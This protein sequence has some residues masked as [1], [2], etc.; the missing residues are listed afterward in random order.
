MLSACLYKLGS[1]D[2]QSFQNVSQALEDRSI[3][4]ASCVFQQKGLI[5]VFTVE[6]GVQHFCNMPNTSAKFRCVKNINQ[7][8]GRVGDVHFTSSSPDGLGSKEVVVPRV[9][10]P[11]RRSLDIGFRVS[12][13][14]CGEQHRR[15]EKLVRQIP[16]FTGS[17]PA[18]IAGGAV[19][20]GSDKPR[21]FP[22]FGGYDSI[23]R[24]CR[25][26][27]ATNAHQPA[28]CRKICE[29]AMGSLDGIAEGE[30]G[31]FDRKRS[32]EFLI[33]QRK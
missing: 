2:A 22:P 15:I 9:S 17:P 5:K 4:Q 24:D 30:G 23:Q 3:S 8:A 18:N 1:L 16:V 6:V 10:D 33:E 31:F 20:L 12:Y 25:V 28:P 13:F 32:V 14:S 7:G 29:E 11:K 19:N 21:V 26:V 27:S